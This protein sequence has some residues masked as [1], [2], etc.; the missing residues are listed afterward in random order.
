[1][2][3][4]DD[5]VAFLASAAAYV[6]YDGPVTAMETHMSWVFLTTE[7]V[8]K[9]K[10][11]LQR[12]LVDLRSLDARYHN[13]GEEL[14]LNRRLGGDTYIG[15]ER[16]GI[17]A[18][19]QLSLGSGVAV[20]WLVV[21]HRLPD[22]A[23]LDSQLAAC[24]VNYSAVARAAILLT[25]FYQQS[26][27]I[28]LSAEQYRQRLEDNVRNNHR[29][30]AAYPVAQ[31]QVERIVGR[32]LTVLGSEA[33]LFSERARR[34]M[35]VEAHGD[36]R[37]EHVCLTEPPVIID[38]LEFSRNLRIQDRVDELAFLAMEC[39]QLGDTWAGEILFETYGQHSGDKPAALLLA[40][41]KAYR[42]CVRAR[43]CAAHL[44]D[45]PEENN[46][47]WLEKAGCYLDMAEAFTAC[48][49]L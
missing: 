44:D 37:P 33:R 1:M 22:D 49:D 3:T 45:G 14:R 17:K 20:D 41:Y 43:L 36:L 24:D 30:L 35:I 18:G 9:L 21:M 48:Y 47:R 26:T 2:P 23:M 13:C 27:P 40:F 38:C 46:A 7:R 34:G 10:K 28:E 19:Q 31:Q 39:Q 15:V 32:Q 16:L 42:A 29:A 11:P 12:D 8:Y 4:L 5:K 6:D 25:D